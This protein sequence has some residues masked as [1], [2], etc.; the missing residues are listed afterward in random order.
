MSVNEQIIEA[1]RNRQ[2]VERIDGIFTYD[3]VLY[4]GVSRYRAM[5]VESFKR[6]G[7]EIDAIEIFHDNAEYWKAKGVMNHVI[8][9]DIRTVEIRKN[10]DVVMWYHGPEHVEKEEAIQ[11]LGKLKKYANHLM[12]VGCPWGQSPQGPEYGNENERHLS[13]WRLPDFAT[14]GFKV[15]AIGLPDQKGSNILAWI[16]K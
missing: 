2:L 7:Y 1:A 4:I 11:V 15:D 10:Y 5:F 6:H 9:A 13:T 12:I 16:Q 14:I 8:C 3:T